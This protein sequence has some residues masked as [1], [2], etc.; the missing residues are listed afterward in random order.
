MRIEDGNCHKPHVILLADDEH[1]N[2]TL[3]SSWLTFDSRKCE[4]FDP[5]D[6]KRILAIIDRYPGG[7]TEFNSCIR[8]L[9]GEL[10]ESVHMTVD[11]TSGLVA[12]VDMKHA[13]QLWRQRSSTCTAAAH[14][15]QDELEIQNELFGEQG[16]EVVDRMVGQTSDAGD[17]GTRPM[18][19][20]ADSFANYDDIA[21]GVDEVHPAIAR[22]GCKMNSYPTEAKD[23]LGDWEMPI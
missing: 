2:A 7:A 13:S 14:A 18:I 10:Y 12:N 23:A 3:A 22:M 11:D 17:D 6:K 8:D 4:C 9:A 5:A 19:N 21:F 1:Q 20:E 15:A 16:A